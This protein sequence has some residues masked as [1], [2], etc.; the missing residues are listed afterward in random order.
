MLAVRRGLLLHDRPGV[1]MTAP[2]D[3]LAELRD[4]E[5]CLYAAANELARCN[6]KDL[7]IVECAALAKACDLLAR[8]IEKRKRPR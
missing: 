8:V 3:A 1:P 7:A 5:D 6:Q 4:A 2:R